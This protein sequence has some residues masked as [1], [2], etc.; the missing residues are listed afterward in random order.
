MRLIVICGVLGAAVSLFGML[1]M[2]GTLRE[3]TTRDLSAEVHLTDFPL[4]KGFGLEPQIVADFLMVELQ[5]RAKNDIAL[6]LAL[7]PDAQKKL[8]EVG[9]PRLVN[10]V[11]VRDMIENIEPLKNVL[12]VGAF[13]TAARVVVKNGGDARTGVALTMPGALLVEAQSGVAAVETTSTGLTALN[14]GD[15]ASGET[16]VLTAWLAQTA[17]EQGTGFS[18]QVLLGDAS[19]ATG[20][21]WIFGQGS[22]KGADLQ[23]MPLARWAVGAVLVAVFLTSILTLVMLVI[24]RRKGRARRVSLA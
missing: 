15:M 19:G 4:P 7:G 21:V 11:V 17:E 20:R 13:R 18:K 24:G 16:R 10:S 3:L 9:I 22:W 12:S 6:R 1:A 8:I 14:L 5:D 2:T 23:A